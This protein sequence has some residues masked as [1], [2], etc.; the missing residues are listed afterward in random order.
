MATQP[1]PPVTFA[2]VSRRVAIRKL[3]R[4]L[5]IFVLVSAV[6]AAVVGFVAERR[7]IV[8]SKT[9][10]WDEVPKPDVLD[11]FQ[12]DTTTRP[13]TL[14]FSA[15]VIPLW[16]PDIK[17]T[18]AAQKILLATNAT[19]DNKTNAWRAYFDARNE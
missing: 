1:T 7:R 17:P 5:V 11:R 3:A 19:D 6:V 10:V 15:G 2:P 18:S 8:T 4:E 14:D 16:Q 12:P 9:V 13:V